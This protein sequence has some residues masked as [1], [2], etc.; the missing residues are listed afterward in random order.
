[1]SNFENLVRTVQAYK[2]ETW[3][4][5]S[6][7]YPFKNIQEP[8]EITIKDF[9]EYVFL[10]LIYIYN[11][12]GI[13]FI[14]RNEKI[15]NSAMNYYFHL[16]RL[17]QQRPKGDIRLTCAGKKMRKKGA[18]PSI[19]MI[20][21]LTT[22]F[23]DCFW[24]YFKKDC[25]KKKHLGIFDFEDSEFGYLFWEDARVFLFQFIN[26]Q[27]LRECIGVSEINMT[28]PENMK[29][30]EDPYVLDHII[31]SNGIYDQ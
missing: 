2:W 15:L 25:K 23:D 14:E 30:E 13:L 7:E 6:V 20:N 19:D 11:R 18:L 8:C 9:I 16:W 21:Y 31:N 3:I 17:H 22:Q 4:Q 26:T 29:K 10:R 12:R 27:Y 24:E 5:S 28:L 1:M